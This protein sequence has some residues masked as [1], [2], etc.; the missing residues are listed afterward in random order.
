MGS[1]IAHRSVRW[2]EPTHRTATVVYA[3]LTGVVG[4]G[5]VAAVRHVFPLFADLRMGPYPVQF[6]A[7]LFY[8]LLVTL[9]LCYVATLVYGRRWRVEAAVIRMS[10]DSIG[11]ELE[12][13]SQVTTVGRVARSVPPLTVEAAR[14]VRGKVKSPG[15]V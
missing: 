2:L 4:A 6:D 1:G 11:R 8:F 9:V 14:R 3:V 10:G 15:V 5:L 7:V 12:P 13:P